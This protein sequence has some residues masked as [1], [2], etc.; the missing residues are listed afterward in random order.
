VTARSIAEA[1]VATSCYFR[2]TVEQPY[3]KALVQINED[4]NLRC[5]H[6]FVSA[7]RIGKQMPLAGCEAGTII[8]VFT[9]RRR[10]RVPVP[11]VRCPDPGLPARR[12]RVHRR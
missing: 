10:H 8:Y 6:C 9:P 3:R 5:A 11:G 7:T 1:G 4:C 12:H 2:T